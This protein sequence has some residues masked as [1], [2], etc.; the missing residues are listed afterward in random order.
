MKKNADMK[1]TNLMQ[2]YHQLVVDVNQAIIKIRGA[3]AAWAKAHEINYHELL[4]LYSIRDMEVATQKKVCDSYFLPKQTVN[5]VVVS[6][7]KRGYVELE[8]REGL[9]KEKAIALT[10]EGQQYFDRIMEQLD[11]CELQSVHEIGAEQL[12]NMIRIAEEYGEILWKL[13]GN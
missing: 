7:K 12:K 11:E 3:Y 6:M 2:E 10:E 8:A 9:G 4:V 1:R 13:Q 5:N